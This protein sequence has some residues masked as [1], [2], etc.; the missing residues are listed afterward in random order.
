MLSQNKCNAVKCTPH[1]NGELTMQW[2]EDF[3]GR[4]CGRGANAGWA[5]IG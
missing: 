3:E 5:F 1:R 2:T 4:A